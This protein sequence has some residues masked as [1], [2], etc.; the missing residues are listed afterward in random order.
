MHVCNSEDFDRFKPASSKAKEE[1]VQRLFK[2]GKIFCLDQEMSS[3]SLKGTE[4]LTQ[5]FNS[6]DAMVIPCASQF[7]LTDGS[8]VGGGD[9]CVWEM[10]TVLDY[11]GKNIN[12]ATYYNQQNFQADKYDENERIEQKSM[13][14]SSYASTQYP[15][16]TEAFVEL[17]EL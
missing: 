15:L 3:F 12:F 1:K 4:S 17:N 9:E 13:L 8:V 5:D 16:W 6:I 11:V 2:A 10:D 14:Y 7:K